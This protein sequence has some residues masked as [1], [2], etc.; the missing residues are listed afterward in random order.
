MK[1]MFFAILSLILACT[2]FAQQVKHVIIITIDGFRPDFYLDSS[3][4]TPH[5]R[6]LLRNGV[7][8]YGVNS[9]LPSITYPSHTTIVTGVQP[10]KHG[11]YYNNMFDETGKSNSPYWHATS[12]HVPTLWSAVHAQ[13]K[14]VAVL[15]WPVS[16]G[17]PVDCDIPDIGSLGDSVREAYSKPAG[18]VNEVKQN[19]F[20]GAAKIEYGKDY[21]V[22][23]IAAYVIAKDQPSLMTTHFFSVDHAEHTVGRI[24]QMVEEAI[25]DAD[26]GVSIIQDAVAKQGLASSTVIIVTGDHGFKNVTTT[27][28]PNVW[29]AQA[30]IIK[31]VKQGDW[32]AMFNSAGGST[33]LYLKDKNDKQTLAQVMD[34][35][36]AQPDS[37]KK[38]FTIED[39]KKM[40]G[41]GGNPEVVFALSGENGA[42]FSNAAT[43]EAIKPGKGGT[44]GFFPDSREIQ[45]GFI[46]SGPGLKNT[47]VMI[48]QMNL[49]DIAP[50]VSKLLN[51]PFPS[52]EGKIPAGILTK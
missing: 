9:V 28:N 42:A 33:F 34:I 17:A 7:Y 47:G 11:V 51:V 36:K 21:N 40:N 4:H 6:Q 44:H 48:Q 22:A 13:G 37:V 29:L 24:G 26:S 27:V 23:R 31:D 20:G 16:A 1:K 39:R 10:V 12:I 38:Y 2:G 46:A 3:W 49:R 41:I 5:L 52:A 14:K 50:L 43:G 45:T 15:L 25:S 8:A 19:V 35:L 30:G 18:F 32:K